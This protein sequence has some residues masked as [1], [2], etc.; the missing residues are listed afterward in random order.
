MKIIG[1][2]AW[3]EEPVEWLASCVTSLAKVCDHVVAL[4]GPYL[5]FSEALEHPTSGPEQAAAILLAANAA[6]IGCTIHVP[7]E[8]WAGEV[9]KR[10]AMFDLGNQIADPMED[11]MLV[12]DADEVVSHVPCDLHKRL[13]DTDKHVAG[14]THWQ[15]NSRHPALRDTDEHPAYNPRPAHERNL[16]H[17]ALFRAI[18]G[19]HVEGNHAVNV[20][21]VDGER[22]YLRGRDDLHDLAP[23]LDLTDLQVEHRHDWRGQWRAQ[24]ARDYATVRDLSGIERLV[25]VT[26]PGLDGEPMKVAR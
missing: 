6:G 14:I 24:A 11:W 3:Y 26:V 17:R 18:P 15:R 16:Y 12:L 21:E 10:T 4:D 13:A 8:P 19:L 1:L 5:L 7:S 2:L 20:C 22:L 23:I 9:E 25:E